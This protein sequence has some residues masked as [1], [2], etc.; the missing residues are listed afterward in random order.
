M[1]T[2]LAAREHRRDTSLAPGGPPRR[3]G[4]HPLFVL[5]AIAAGAVATIALWWQDTPSIH[6]LGD[7]LTNA[8]RITGLLAG[9]GVVVLVAL[10]ARIPPLERGIGA[11]KLARWHSRGRPVHGQPRR[12]ARPADHLGLRGHRAHR[13]REPD[14]DAAAQLSGRA[15]GDA[16]RIAARRRRRGLGTRGA[17]ADAVRDLVLPALL[18]LPRGRAGVQPSVRHRRRLHRQPRRRGSPGRRCT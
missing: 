17:A 6:G 18:H 8:G 12:R 7:W 3:P 1:T 5:G 2:S 9:Y 14:Q 11:D 13:R 16:R 15:H 10:M 4:A